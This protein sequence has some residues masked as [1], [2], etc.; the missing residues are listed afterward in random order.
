M[1]I[2][3][4]NVMTRQKEEFKPYVPAEETDEREELA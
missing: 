1:T 4:Y 2:K 3:V